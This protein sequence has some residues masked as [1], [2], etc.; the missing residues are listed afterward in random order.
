[1]DYVWYVGYGS[2][3]SEKRFLCYIRGGTPRFGKKCNNG[4]KKDK[5][6]LVENKP[7]II[8]YRLYFALPDGNKKTCNWGKGG[9]A[10]ISPHEDKISKTLCRMLKITRNQY[11]D[12]RKQEGCSWYCMEILL[13][14]DDGVPI[15]IITNQ[16]D[17]SN[18]LCPSNCYIKTIALGI[19]ETYTS[20]EEEITKYL[21]TKEGIRGNLHEEQVRKLITSTKNE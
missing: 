6:L 15:Y 8:H 7:G 20:N 4:C 19:K 11:D 21:I 10:F 9:I 1:M 3:L 17:L 2:N 12:V 5:S 18:I 16:D 14:E 13:G